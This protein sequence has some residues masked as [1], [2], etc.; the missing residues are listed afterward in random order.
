MHLYDLS[1][2]YCPRDEAQLSSLMTATTRHVHD[3]MRKVSAAARCLQ[4]VYYSGS[5]CFRCVTI[6]DAML[7]SHVRHPGIYL[8][9]FRKD[10][11]LS[12]SFF[13]TFATAISKS[14]CTRAQICEC[15]DAYHDTR[16]IITY[17]SPSHILCRQC[18]ISAVDPVNYVYCW[19]RN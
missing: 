11:F 9:S 2:D 16:D 13:M 7:Q 15:H 10:M 12:E 6:T 17:I 14:S 19:A 4:T 5:H 1:Q 8:K 18:G 3:S